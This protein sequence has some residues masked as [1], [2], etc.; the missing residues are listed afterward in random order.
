M[1]RRF[2]SFSFLIIPPG[3]TYSHAVPCKGTAG[4]RYPA[5]QAV[6][7]IK[8]LGYSKIIL[9]SDNE[10]AILELRRAACYILRKEHGMTVIEE[11]SPVEDHQANGVV[12]NANGQFGG[13]AHTLNDHLIANYGWTPPTKHPVYTW[14]INHSSFLLTRFQVGVDGKTAWQRFKGKQY[15]RSLPMFAEH[16]LYL[17]VRTTE[18]RKNKLAPKWEDGIFLG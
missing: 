9:K 11:E 15:K 5:R 17:P 10:P 12:E 13:M 1:R 6:Y 3:L 7:S 2:L 14:L 16:V 4:S 8:Q 18:Q